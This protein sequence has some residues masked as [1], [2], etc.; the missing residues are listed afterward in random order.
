MNTYYSGQSTPPAGLF[1][2]GLL[3]GPPWINVSRPDRLTILP[4]RTD[5]A[6]FIQRAVRPARSPRNGRVSA[7]PGWVGKLKTSSHPLRDGIHE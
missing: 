5:V 6:R 7:R 2:F 3:D 4:A 1:S